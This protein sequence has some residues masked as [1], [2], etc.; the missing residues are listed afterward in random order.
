MQ[1]TK[2]QFFHAI[3]L[4][5]FFVSCNQFAYNNAGFGGGFGLSNNENSPVIEKSKDERNIGTKT[6]DFDPTLFELDTLGSSKNLIAYSKPAKPNTFTKLKI[7]L[8]TILFQTKLPKSQFVED[9][10]NWLRSTFPQKENKPE[11]AN[12]PNKNFK[13]LLKNK[14]YYDEDQVNKGL[15]I[16]GICAGILLIMILIA[17][18]SP[19]VL[20]ESGNGCLFVIACLSLGGGVLYGL[21][22]A[23]IG[24]II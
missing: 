6:I 16:A 5:I 13:K 1:P 9:Y 18:A 8:I 21:I 3:L 11:T 22:M 17:T 12:Q 19:S 15:S 14:K 7:K 4:F 24:A 20:S 23:L 10:G 2:F